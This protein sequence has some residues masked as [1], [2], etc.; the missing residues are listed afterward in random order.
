MVRQESLGQAEKHLLHDLD[1]I[2]HATARLMV[3]TYLY[4]VD[5]AAYVFLTR[6]TGLTWGNLSAHLAKLEN[7]GYARLE[8]G[9]RGKRP[10]IMIMLTNEG[11]EAFLKYKRQMEAA[12]RVM[13]G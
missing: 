3:L 7:A 10:H 2:I 1:R 9:D 12:V 13:P 4:V 11:R 5:S 6:L 8:K